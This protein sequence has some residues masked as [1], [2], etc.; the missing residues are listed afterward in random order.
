[1]FESFTLSTSITNGCETIITNM[2]KGTCG[3]QPG[4]HQAVFL[5][6]I[7][8]CAVELPDDL[9]TDRYNNNSFCYH[10]PVDYMNLF[11]S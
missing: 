4:R 5:Y 6:G 1:M 2:S 11:N 10:V 3:Y 9:Y 8:G 7:T